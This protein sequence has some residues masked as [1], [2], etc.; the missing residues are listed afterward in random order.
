M[1]GV[2]V[3]VTTATV[4]ATAQ[5]TIQESTEEQATEEQAA[6]TATACDTTQGETIFDGGANSSQIWDQSKV[7]DPG[8]FN[9]Q[10]L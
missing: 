5:D 4:A 2:T 9:S 7:F 6:A 10:T 3:A 1:A 8:R